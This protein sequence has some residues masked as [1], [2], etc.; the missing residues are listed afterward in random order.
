MLN[1]G[2]SHENSSVHQQL[3]V[4]QGTIEI[5]NQ[6][7]TIAHGLSK[8]NVKAHTLNYY[9][10]Y[11]NYSSEFEIEAGDW[12]DFNQPLLMKE[13]IE[14]SI[15]PNFDMFHFHFLHTL[16]PNFN[17]LPII[18][19][20]QKPMLFHHWG[21][22][23]RTLNKALEINPYAKAK[24]SDPHYI[25]SNLRQI[26]TYIPYCIVADH[27]LLRYVEDYYEKIYM[28]PTSVDIA[29]YPFIKQQQK[30]PFI[31]HAPTNYQIKG[32]NDIINAITRLQA[33]FDFDFQLITGTSHHKAKKIYEQA[34]IIIDQL[35]IGT[36]GLLAVEC[37]ALGKP[38][39]CHISDYMKEHYPDDLPIISANPN[40]IY[41]VLRNTLQNQDQLPSISVQSRN[42]AMKHH[43]HMKNSQKLLQVYKEILSKNERGAS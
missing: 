7:Q 42:Y 2:E 14:H 21:S 32:S 39:I 30:K 25:E 16:L 9:P 19:A 35:H 5:A 28:I 27:E 8:I 17:D 43:D 13:H 12:K 26:S 33:E 38:T 6:M 10:S 36:Y 1:E 3:R 23:V 4:L 31:V 29:K 40:T 34:D 37:M 41:Q 18:K 24:V 20:H 11:L 15:I 22:D